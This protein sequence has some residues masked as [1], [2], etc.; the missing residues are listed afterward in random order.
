[1]AQLQI[2]IPNAKVNLLKSALG[3]QDTIIDENGDEVANP[4]SAKDFA[5]EYLINIL[6]KQVKNYEK[7]QALQNA[8]LTDTSDFTQT[9]GQ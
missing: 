6:K 2:E 5:E 3:Y 1:M 4:Q 7:R 9:S 8:T